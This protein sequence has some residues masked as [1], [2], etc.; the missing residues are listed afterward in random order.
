VPPYHPSIRPDSTLFVY[1]F[2]ICSIHDERSETV[3]ARL[4][5]GNPRVDV[6]TV[7]EEDLDSGRLMLTSLNSTIIRPLF[8]SLW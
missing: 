4:L 8:G 1:G 2:P 3:A 7:L 6:G 5:N